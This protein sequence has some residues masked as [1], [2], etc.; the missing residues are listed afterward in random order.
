MPNDKVSVRSSAILT[1]SYVAGTVLGPAH[2]LDAHN[3]VNL[4]INFTIGSLTS[5]EIKIEFSNDGDVTSPTYGQETF[6]V[7]SGGTSTETLGIH[8]YT[9]S[10]TYVLSIPVKWRYMKISAKGT[11]TVTGSLLDITAILGD[12]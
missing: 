12:V 8:Q 5:L 7:I 4:L 1:T 10:G 2:N 11:G 6:Q 3:Q 9:A